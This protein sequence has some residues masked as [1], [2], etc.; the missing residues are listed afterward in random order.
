MGLWPQPCTEGSAFCNGAHLGISYL[1]FLIQKTL[2]TRP[3]LHWSRVE[4]TENRAGGKVA[5][6]MVW[7]TCKLD[8]KGGDRETGL[9]VTGGS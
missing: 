3:G 2:W 5:L 1:R 4:G 9:T 7:A 8:R 6:L